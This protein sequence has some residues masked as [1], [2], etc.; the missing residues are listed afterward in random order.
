MSQNLV[1]EQW[2]ILTGETWYGPIPSADG[3]GLAKSRSV[4][5][6]SWPGQIDPNLMRLN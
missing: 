2:N 6:C 1:E 5:I 3:V 4:L